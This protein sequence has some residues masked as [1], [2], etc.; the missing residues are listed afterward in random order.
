MSRPSSRKCQCYP[1]LNLCETSRNFVLRSALKP[2]GVNKGPA[3]IA[4]HLVPWAPL[5]QSYS[6]AKIDCGL[7]R[8]AFFPFE[9]SGSKFRVC[10]SVHLHTFKRINQLDAAIN[11]RFIVYRLDNRSTCFGHPYAHHQEPIN[12]SSSLWFTVVTWW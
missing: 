2:I 11:Y 10:R 9:R 8:T 7:F 4:A 6:N 12:C 1:K 3:D 5:P